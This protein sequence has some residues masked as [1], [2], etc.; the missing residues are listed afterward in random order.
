VLA[1]HR[2]QP[3]DVIVAEAFLRGALIAAEAANVPRVAFLTTVNCV[4][5]PGAPA[6]G[7]GF[8][9]ARGPAGRARDR[10]VSA[11]SRRMWNAG[12][13]RLNAARTSVGLP[14]VDDVQADMASE[15]PLLV[16]SPRALEYPEARPPAERALRR[17]RGCSTRRGSSRG[18]RRRATSRSS[19][20][21]SARP[22]WRRTRCCADAPGRSLRCRCAAW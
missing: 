17:P 2:R 7:A 1:E 18:R 5:T 21:A 9:P 8:A 19:S 11:I 14:P 12:L 20:S 4:P 15:D 6:F 16:L 22:T 3:A 10:A 13:E